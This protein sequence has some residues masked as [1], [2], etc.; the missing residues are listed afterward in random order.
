MGS[1]ET[2]K[3]LVQERNSIDEMNDSDTWLKENPNLSHTVF[4]ETY[5]P[6]D[7]LK[8]ENDGYCVASLPI[9]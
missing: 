8:G 4:H 5:Q 9:Y 1:S 7:I 6:D 2:I 3:Y